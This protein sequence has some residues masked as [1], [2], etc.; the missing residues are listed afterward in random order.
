M[1]AL[2]AFE[3]AG[4]LGSFNKAADELGV[5]RSAISH[6]I[7]LLEEQLGVVLFRRDQ[8]QAQLSNAGQVYFPTVRDALDRIDAQ[9]QLIKPVKGE[10][11]LTIQAYVTVALK[12]LLPRLHFAHQRALTPPK[13]VDIQ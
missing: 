5:T 11:E 4:R 8:R 13:D 10:D 7:R 12:W 1:R 9:T 6:Q 3:T 2:I